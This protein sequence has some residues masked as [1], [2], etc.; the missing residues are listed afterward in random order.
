MKCQKMKFWTR[1]DA[2]QE[3]ISIHIFNRTNSKKCKN[4]Q[5][6]NRKMRV[7]LC[8]KCGAYHLTTASAASVR[9]FA[10]MTKN[11]VRAVGA[12]GG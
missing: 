1:A 5:K 8:S 10:R 7:Y 9:R 2:L 12:D 6:H 4:S 3:I 11:T